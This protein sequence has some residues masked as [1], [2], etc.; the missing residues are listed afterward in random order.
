MSSSWHDFLFASMDRSGLMTV[1]KP[2]LAVWVQAL[3]ARIFGFNSLSILVPAGA[4]G[5]RRG[6]LMYDLVRRRFGRVAGFVAG[7][8]LASTPTI[9][10]VSRHNNPDELL[11]LLS[12]AAVWCALRA[13]ETGRTR[14]LVWCGV[15]SGSGS[16]RR[17]A[18]R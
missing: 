6:G 13:L 16:R 9:V 17:W 1:D 5:R 7:I 15:A 12:V 4:D 2:P 8:A 11:V 18:S 14:W 3:S 10:A